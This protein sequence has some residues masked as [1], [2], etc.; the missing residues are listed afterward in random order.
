M[1]TLYNIKSLF[2]FLYKLHGRSKAKLP[3]IGLT[4]LQARV[5]SDLYYL[6]LYECVMYVFSLDFSKK[7]T[8]IISNLYL[9]SWFF[10][11]KATLILKPYSLLFARQLLYLIE[12]KKLIFKPGRIFK[13]ESFYAERRI[14]YCNKYFFFR[15]N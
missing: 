5:N 14:K 10:E 7:L 4:Y 6:H 9:R 15:K 12:K 1:C 11:N 13:L 3:H 2:L 8:N